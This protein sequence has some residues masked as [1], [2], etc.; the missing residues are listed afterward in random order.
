MTSQNF[1]YWLQGY[2]ELSS[3][4]LFDEAQI[5]VMRQH[6]DLAIAYDEMQPHPD[7]TEAMKFIRELHK[8]LHTSHMKEISPAGGMS[9]ED[10]L[11]GLFKH[12][13]DTPDPT[14]AL[15]AA[16]DGEEQLSP[17]ELANLPYWDPRGPNYDPHARC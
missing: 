3:N 8:A 6:C 11:S 9:L 13:I 4:R 17:A 1:C 16:H 7:P 5:K 14:G 12:E 10:R 2:F 15:Q